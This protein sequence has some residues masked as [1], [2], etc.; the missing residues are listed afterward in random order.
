[1][2][3]NGRELKTCLRNS[4]YLLNIKDNYYNSVEE[5]KEKHPDYYVQT[6][7]E[8]VVEIRQKDGYFGEVL[9]RKYYLADGVSIFHLEQHFDILP[10]DF[11]FDYF[12][13]FMLSAQDELHVKD[14]LNFHLK[15]TFDN[16]LSNLLNYL[17]IIL[18]KYDEKNE[19]KYE[20]FITS[21]II[22]ISNMWIEEN[23]TG[24]NTQ[25]NAYQ[26]TIKWK[27]TQTQL[28]CLVYSLFYSGLLENESNQRTKLTHEIAALF[29]IEINNLNS[30]IKNIKAAK[31]DTV[32]KGF[33]KQLQN[34][35]A[36]IKEEAIE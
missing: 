32:L 18:L 3:C 29:G 1:M 8:L 11:G 15:N 27:G 28:T 9:S 6:E 24:I 19:D 25:I 7:P 2:L 17:R 23:T 21:S 14:F 13:A 12:F 36:K 16:V 30:I 33:I 34:G 26:S 10:E 31:N 35:Y 5:F 22:T 20:I 4:I